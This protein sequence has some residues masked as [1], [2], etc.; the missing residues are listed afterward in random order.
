VGWRVG[1]TPTSV[2]TSLTANDPSGGSRTRRECRIL[3]DVTATPRPFD[4]VILGGGVAG[5]ATALALR[6]RVDR[7]IVIEATSY[8]S[9]R[10]GESVPP[11]T[12]ALL[13]ELGIWDA[14]TRQGHS[15]CLGSRSV[16]GSAA[17][18]YNDFLRHPLGHGWHLERQRF[19]R[20]MADQVQASGIELQTGVRYTHAQPARGGGFVLEL[21]GAPERARLH[22]R[23]VVDATGRQARFAQGRG[24]RRLL[25][26]QL[27]CSAGYFDLPREHDF[28]DFTWLEAVEYGWWYAARL[29]GGRVTAV[30][31]TDPRLLRA[32]GLN[33]RDAWLSSLRGTQLLGP[34]FAP[35]QPSAESPT[36]WVAA[37]SV[38]A[39]P[40]DVG[41]L[42]V[43]DAAAAYD[44]ISSLG[45]YKALADG[46][47]AAQVIAPALDNPRT[48]LAPY[49]QSVATGF[50]R[51]LLQRNQSY[52]D[53]TRWPLAPFWQTR[54][55]RTALAFGATDDSRRSTA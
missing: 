39:P 24:A 50:S 45:V 33:Q 27:I 5:C 31:A 54:H 19:D 55:E 23:F 28:D 21:I 40:A 32:R 49:I 53:E 38:L 1:A 2:A 47:R 20:F 16:W 10:V 15:A 3:D 26:D 6:G 14:F 34:A 22:A 17:V 13:S 25:H 7:V 29:P 18:G 51:Y 42:A 30:V 11:D 37:S 48:P 52:L 9:P 43:G 35:L 36:L 12:R 8:G 4:V 41:W 44:P 46:L